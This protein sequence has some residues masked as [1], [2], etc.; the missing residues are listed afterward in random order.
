MLKANGPPFN[1]HII[2]LSREAMA[3]SDIE[4]PYAPQKLYSLAKNVPLDSLCHF[5]DEE[6][7]RCI[8]NYFGTF[9]EKQSA[10]V[11]FLSK[12]L[13]N[14]NFAAGLTEKENFFLIAIL[15]DLVNTFKKRVNKRQ[16]LNANDANL[17]GIYLEY[18][19]EENN[20]LFDIAKLRLVDEQMIS[21][22][23]EFCKLNSENLF[24]HYKFNDS[25][26]FFC[27]KWANVHQKMT[28]FC[29]PSFATNA[30]RRWLSISGQSEKEM[31][32]EMSKFA[33]MSGEQRQIV[34]FWMTVL[35]SKMH[36]LC[37]KWK[38]I[39]LFI[40][41]R[42]GEML[43]NSLNSGDISKENMD[44][45]LISVESETEFANICANFSKFWRGCHFDDQKLLF[46]WH[47]ICEQ[48]QKTPID[49]L[50]ELLKAA[51]E[52]K[53]TYSPKESHEKMD[54]TAEKLSKSNS[55]KMDKRAE[56]L[57]KPSTKVPKSVNKL[58]ES[59]ST[60][61]MSSSPSSSFREKNIGTEKLAEKL[62]KTKLGKQ[63][64][65]TTRCKICEKEGKKLSSFANCHDK[66]SG[67]QE[68]LDLFEQKCPK[69]RENGNS[70]RKLSH[71][72][73]TFP[74]CFQQGTND[75][76]PKKEKND[77]EKQKKKEEE[78]SDQK[79]KKEEGS[80]QKK[81][82]EEGSDQKKKKEE[83]SDQKKKEEEGSDQ[84]KKEEEG[85][86]QKKK[87][88]VIRKG[89]TK[90]DQQKKEKEEMIN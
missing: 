75:H 72:F 53:I 69:C 70:R 34:K 16:Q 41:K 24:L 27:K 40:L 20:P 78:G 58:S 31:T 19:R 29:I 26:N 2:P 84:K 30:F 68:C 33:E 59:K 81:K 44:N 21:L 42:T 50:E 15:K 51:P 67:C 46:P 90:I 9:E 61:A 45:L 18:F 52:I 54:K 86:D 37:S 12:W 3:I 14:S 55:T 66:H 47:N 43:E 5:R 13:R 57:P 25:A 88:E 1:V 74:H 62:Q 77:Y 79:K 32:D 89:K 82:E 60:R 35:S 38:G 6:T 11:G 23:E 17:V 48:I 63:L 65:S 85:S 36:Y 76:L 8:L 4:N 56:K 87:K 80:D 83:G 73:P 22:M 64:A 49:P 28:L 10:V 7:N 39:D 71:C